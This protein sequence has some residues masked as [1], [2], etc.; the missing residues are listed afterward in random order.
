[1]SDTFTVIVHLPQPVDA[2]AKLMSTVH[3]IWP[4]ATLDVTGAWKIEVDAC[5]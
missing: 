4:E 3:D 2:V 5:E 1:M